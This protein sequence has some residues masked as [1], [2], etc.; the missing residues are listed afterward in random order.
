MYVSHGQKTKKI[1]GQDSQLQYHS[2]LSVKKKGLTLQFRLTLKQADVFT[3]WVE[4]F[5]AASEKLP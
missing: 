4:A 2:G 5:W 3:F 1:S